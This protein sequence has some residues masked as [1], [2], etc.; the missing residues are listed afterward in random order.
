M[1]S[2]TWW[3]ASEM[4]GHHSVEFCPQPHETVGVHSRDEK[5]GRL[6]L[7]LGKVGEDFKA[8]EGLA[9]PVADLG[10][11]MAHKTPGIVDW[12]RDGKVDLLVSVADGMRLFLHEADGSLKETTT[13]LPSLEGRSPSLSIVTVDWT[14][15]G[16]DD[17]L[18]IE[19]QALVLL[20]RNGSEAFLPAF[21]VFR[22]S[23]HDG[24]PTVTGGAVA[25]WDEDGLFDILVGLASGR[26]LHWRQ[27]ASGQ[28]QLVPE[29]RAWYGIQ[30]QLAALTSMSSG[31]VYSVGCSL[32]EAAF[33]S[34]SADV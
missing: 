24:L 22:W 7:G 32:I 27:L 15:D 12:N 3:W 9:N 19:K 11:G 33:A 23:L 17:V 25:D 2:W 20:E 26:L 30:K 6:D 34:H 14:M 21:E 16:H 13:K 31:P 10:L 29:A 8:Q 28:M 1:G 18:L 5:D 4:L